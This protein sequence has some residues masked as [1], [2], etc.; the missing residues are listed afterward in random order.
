MNKF[1][2]V[3]ETVQD[4]LKAMKDAEVDI[5]YYIQDPKKKHASAIDSTL[6]INKETA[7]KKAK[8]MGLKAE[9][10]PGIYG[11]GVN[12]YDMPKKYKLSNE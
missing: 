7:E 3:F 4:A 12:K 8:R 2:K 9:L 10:W 11:H 6:Y 1:D 5:S